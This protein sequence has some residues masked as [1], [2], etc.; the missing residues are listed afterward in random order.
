M[1]AIGAVFIF[2]SLHLVNG[3]ISL[4]KKNLQIKSILS[5]QSV[6]EKNPLKSMLTFEGLKENTQSI[7]FS[8]KLFLN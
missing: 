7:L 8:S 2:L 3:S 1:F 4:P 6:N 5:S